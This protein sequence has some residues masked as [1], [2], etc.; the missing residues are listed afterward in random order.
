MSL[1]S[2]LD[3]AGAHTHTRLVCTG[4]LFPMAGSSTPRST[5]DDDG[6]NDNDDHDDDGS[7]GCGC[8]CG[9]CGGDDDN[10]NNNNN[11]NDD[12]TYD[13]DDD[14]T[15]DDDDDDDTNDDDIND[16][17]IAGSVH[18]PYSS[19]VCH[20]EPLTFDLPI[21]DVLNLLNTQT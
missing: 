12:D 10:N 1:T 9:D 2:L 7:C 4:R 11:D 5:N 3:R 21:G 6:D 14:D 8:G 17:M 13:D 19:L 15:N 16:D 20:F 18:H